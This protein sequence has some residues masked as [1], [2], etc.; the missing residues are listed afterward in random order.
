ME[1]ENLCTEFKFQYKVSKE[2]IDTLRRVFATA[3]N[4]VIEYE[5][6]RYNVKNGKIKYVNKVIKKH[7]ASIRNVERTLEKYCE[8][9]EWI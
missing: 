8:V 7:F 3:N 4:M 5:G 9:V 6:K 1:T 2:T